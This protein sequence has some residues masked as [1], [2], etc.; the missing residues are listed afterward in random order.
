M[1]LPTI[2]KINDKRHFQ[3]LLED[4]PGVFIIKF[5]AT[6]CGPCKKIEKDV[7]EYVNGMPMNV[8]C[9]IVDVDECM[10]VYGFLRTKKMV[11][12]IP[13]L[14]A[15]YNGNTSYIPDEFVCSSDKK[16]VQFFFDTCL[17]EAN[18]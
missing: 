14:L 3:K 2:T 1:P 13:A 4:N 7:E 16:D 8:Q 9:A 6:W 11:K 17:E 18:A 5:G 15:Y 12:A 10:E